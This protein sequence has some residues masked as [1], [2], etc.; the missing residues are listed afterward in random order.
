ME[1]CAVVVAATVDVD[2]REGVGGRLAT[3]GMGRAHPSLLQIS[4]IMESHS[5]CTRESTKSSCQTTPPNVT[6]AKNAI[7][8]DM[9]RRFGEGVR[10]WLVHLEE[11]VE[12]V[13]LTHELPVD[14][15]LRHLRVGV[16]HLLCKH[17]EHVVIRPTECS[18]TRAANSR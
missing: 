7:L 9:R 8:R 3:S 15:D 18:A 11:V 6:P 17:S 16:P 10:E 5:P 14:Q 4:T 2:E 1:V 12:L 13:R